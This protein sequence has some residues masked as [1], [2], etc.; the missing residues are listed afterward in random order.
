[1]ILVFCLGDLKAGRILTVYLETV[2]IFL[3]MIIKSQLAL[4]SLMGIV[5]NMLITVIQHTQNQA[6]R[7]L[8]NTVANHSVCVW[9]EKDGVEIEVNFNTLKAG[10][11]VIINASEVIPVDSVI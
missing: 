10:D 11:I 9:N 4:T 5:G 1:M 3:G 8:T 2:V 6:T 7:R